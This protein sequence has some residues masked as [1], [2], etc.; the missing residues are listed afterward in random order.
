[1]AKEDSRITALQSG[2]T[3]P[4]DL[5]DCFVRKFRRLIKSPGLNENKY[6]ENKA[7]EKMRI[8]TSETTKLVQEIENQDGL[9]HSLVVNSVFTQM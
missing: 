4:E 6:T 3:L 9:F 7:E 8:L 5:I 2:G 1:M